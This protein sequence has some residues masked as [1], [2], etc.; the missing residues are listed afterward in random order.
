[1]ASSFEIAQMCV[2]YIGLLFLSA[3]LI[4]TIIQIIIFSTTQIYRRNPC[5]F[6]FL[7]ASVHEFGE[8]I[9]GFA[10]QVIATSLNIN[11][12]NSSPIWCK[13]RYPFTTSCAVIPL[14]FTCFATIDQFLVTAKNARHRLKSN[15]KYAHIISVPII[16]FWWLH[17]LIWIPFQEL[18]RS[19]GICIYTS[20]LFHIYGGIFVVI[21]M[22]GF[23]VTVMV[24]FGILAYRNIR[25]TIVLAN[26]HVDRQLTIMVCI[27]VVL[28][29][30][31][32]SPWAIHT[33]YAIATARVYKDSE[34]IALESL[35]YTVDYIIGSLAYGVIMLY[36]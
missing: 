7:L 5:T 6:Y 3:G 2:L 17:G 15:I 35:I 27:Q 9:F 21:I 25:Q 36:H 32:L 1:M 23:H 22:A 26:Q 8:F 12:A 28:I 13:L 30:I 20:E 31:S 4:G 14:T 24:I 11:L 18:S 19:S 34:R 29:L 10:P 16:I 33:I